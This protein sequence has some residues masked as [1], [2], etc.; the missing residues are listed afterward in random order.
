MDAAQEQFFRRVEY[1]PNAG[2][3]LWSGGVGCGGYG[4]FRHGGAS[5]AHRVSYAW[6]KGP[7]PAGF[8][9]MHKCDTP[10]CVNPEHLSAGTQGDN[11]ADRQAK[12]RSRGGDRR[13]ERNRM[14]KLTEFQVSCI[15]LRLREGQTQASIAADFGV[16]HQTISD[17]ARGRRRQSTPNQKAA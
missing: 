9:V 1:D 16:A 8:V 4:R 3:W 7:I 15:R 2:C 13:G 6:A 5:L 12:G 17:I 11:N 10:A 14:S